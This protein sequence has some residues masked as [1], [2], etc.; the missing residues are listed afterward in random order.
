MWVVEGEPVAPPLGDGEPLSVGAKPV[1]EAEGVSVDEKVALPVAQGVTER[2]V[3]ED[4]VARGPVGVEAC[5]TLVVPRDVPVAPEIDTEGAPEAEALPVM[6][7]QALTEEVCV[8]R[9]DALPEGV[10]RTVPEAVGVT[11]AEPVA[12]PAEGVPPADAVGDTPPLRVTRAGEAELEGVPL[13]QALTLEVKHAEGVAQP[14]AVGDA[15]PLLPPLLEGVSDSVHDAETLPAAPAA[16][17]ALEAVGGATDGEVVTDA[18]H[19]GLLDA[20]AVAVRVS[21]APIERVGSAP[22]GVSGAEG[23]SAGVPVGRAPV[24][25]AVALGAAEPVAQPVGVTVPRADAELE[26][27]TVVVTVSVGVSDGDWLTLSA[28][29]GV[30]ELEA[31]AVMDTDVVEERE[32]S[33]EGVWDTVPEA[34]GETPLALGVAAR[35]PEGELDGDTAPTVGVADTVA[36]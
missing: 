12:A 28:S 34:D 23:E 3:V 22:V 4:R 6:E 17:A 15:V 36:E 27:D 30:A 25:L 21:A 16:P 29:D 31:E 33:G 9:L 18:V 14:E 10:A 1:C 13:S 19:E 5:V 32:G 2:E 35:A 8:S 11:L 20:D 26:P 24:P 7:G